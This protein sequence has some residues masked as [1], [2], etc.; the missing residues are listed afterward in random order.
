MKSEAWYLRQGRLGVESCP[1]APWFPRSAMRSQS[2]S[3]TTFPVE[4]ATDRGA[5]ADLTNFHAG[6]MISAGFISSGG[7][8]SAAE[9]G[10]PNSDR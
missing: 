5:Y 6:A 1:W 10:S 9:G 2:G 4:T 3:S 7:R 8:R